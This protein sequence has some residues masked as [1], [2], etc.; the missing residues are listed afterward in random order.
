MGLLLVFLG[1]FAKF[2][3]GDGMHPVLLLFMLGCMGILVGG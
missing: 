1:I 3:E 2:S